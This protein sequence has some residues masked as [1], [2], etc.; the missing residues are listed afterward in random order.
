[1]DLFHPEDLSGK[2][3]PALFE[4]LGK[5]SPLTPSLP[6]CLLFNC[7]VVSDS[8]RPHDLWPTGLL[9]RWDSPGKNT[10]VGCHFFFQGIFLIQGSNPCLLCLLQWQADILPLSHLGSLTPLKNENVSFLV[11]SSPPGSSV[12]IFRQED[13]SGLPFPSLGNLTQG[14]NPGVPL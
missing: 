1:M 8:L 14:S 13:R 5:T 6:C 3:G 4:K 9:C 11:V 10:G 2:L 7:Q 12:K